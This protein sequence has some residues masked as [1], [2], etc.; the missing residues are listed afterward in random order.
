[1]VLW[2]TLWDSICG[3]NDQ[4]VEANVMKSVSVADESEFEEGGIDEV[5]KQKGVGR[6]KSALSPF[7]IM[8][9]VIKT[10]LEM[11]KKNKKVVVRK[12]ANRLVKKRMLNNVKKS[13]KLEKTDRKNKIVI[14]LNVNVNYKKWDVTK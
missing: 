14:D 2:P 12:L 10:Q 7:Q 5:N 4:K 3:K 11:R 6:V 8:K 13:K 9:N 1:M